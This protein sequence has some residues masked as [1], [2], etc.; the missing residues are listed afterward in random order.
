MYY[1]VKIE[2]RREGFTIMDAFTEFLGELTGKLSGFEDIIAASAL[3][4]VSYTHLA[5]VTIVSLVSEALLAT[6]ASYSD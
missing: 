1:N 2:N 4:S 6:I 5:S 3:I